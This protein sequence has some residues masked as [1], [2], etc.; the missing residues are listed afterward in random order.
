MEFATFI[1]IMRIVCALCHT[2][3]RSVQKKQEA[4]P[5]GDVPRPMYSN[6]RKDPNNKPGKQACRDVHIIATFVRKGKAFLPRFAFFVTYD[7][8]QL[9]DRCNYSNNT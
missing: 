5:I 8:P 1:T 4:P 7:N 9:K 3:L 2:A 6:K